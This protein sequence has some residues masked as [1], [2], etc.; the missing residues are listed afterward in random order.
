METIRFSLR[1]HKFINRGF[2][3]GPLCPI[4]GIGMVAIIFFL[5]PF[6]NNIVLLFLLGAI[7]AST[8]EYFTGFILEKLFKTRWWDYTKVKYNIN[9]YV[10]LRNT[11]Y[12]GVLCT[13]MIHIVQ[14]LV[15]SFID[16]FT[17]NILHSFTIISLAI[18]LVDLTITIIN[19]L[20]LRGYISGFNLASKL[21]ASNKNNILDL[22]CKLANN[23][24]KIIDYIKHLKG[25]D[26]KELKPHLFQL[27][28][29]VSHNN[30]QL[31]R[32]YHN[33][34]PI[35]KEEHSSIIKD[36]LHK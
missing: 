14:P 31:K 20:K 21:E 17:N 13:I 10:C 32:V 33:Y 18:F 29:L 9:G 34:N 30:A 12:W 36:F 28:K 15:V 16:H 22:Q 11:M 7:V 19:L 23:H 5:E 8:L 27:E 26:H 3:N 24:L 4:Y 2:V 6:H 25:L 35:T 1:E